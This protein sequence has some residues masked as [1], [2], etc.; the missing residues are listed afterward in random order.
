LQY[1][2][3]SF[4]SGTAYQ[5]LNNSVLG[6]YRA[7]NYRFTFKGSLLNT[8]GE[9]ETQFLRQL[10]TI[11]RTVSWVEV[12]VMGEQEKSSFLLSDNDSLAAGSF[13]F[14]WWEVYVTNSDTTANRFR[15][16]Y[17]Q[18]E[19]FN[20]NTEGSRFKR[21][22]L[23][24]DVNYEMDLLKNPQHQLR[25][26][27]TYRRLQILDSSLTQFEPENTVLG[28]VDYGTRFLKNVISSNTYYEI[29]SGLEVRKE[30]S[31]LEVTPGQGNYYWSKEETDY[32]N[33]GIPELNEFEIAQYQDQGNYI[34]V[35]T[36]TNDFVKTFTN[37]FNQ[38]L[39]IKPES[40]WGDKKGIR[41]A[42]SL[43]S[44]KAAYQVNRKTSD[45]ADLYNPFLRSVEDSSLISISNAFLNTFYINRT[46]PVF[47][48][49]LNYRENSS[50]TLLTS[51]FDLRS[52][53]ERGIRARWSISR[54]FMLESLYEE[55]NKS[56]LSEFLGG[57]NFKIDY[58]EV[59]P[60]LSY[61]SGVSFR[62]S[63]YFNY[64]Q[65]KNKTDFGGER[66]FNRTSGVEVRYNVAAKGSFL[67][68]VNYIDIIYNGDTRSPLAYEMLDALQ[69][70]KNATWAVSYQ[71]SLNKNMQ[72]SLN[73]NGRDSEG[74]RTVHAGGAQVRAFF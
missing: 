65:Q 40:Y 2:I 15:L 57:R 63:V 52:N 7:G 6:N 73:Y 61:Q 21:I 23:G 55:G 10:G 66:S 72:L 44:N 37:G 71:R 60:K 45:E 1:E 62:L 35:F 38:V 28:K 48:V 11:S 22:T 13:E 14:R 32:N 39:F 34:R 30:F 69:P 59:E 51:G 26:K 17:R 41:K 8:T 70:G 68:T 43:F 27:A 47:G 5:G 9:V 49:E 74:A 24:E 42:L 36:P 12:G 53:I 64:L 20:P 33:N 18:R 50:K 19:D 58:E 46:S 31:F 67:A 3:S 16:S 25:L 54:K 29:G 4:T 56:S